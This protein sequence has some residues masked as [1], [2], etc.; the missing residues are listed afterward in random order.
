M[1]NEQEPNQGHAEC[2]LQDTSLKT[3]K[4][5]YHHGDLRTVL[6]DNAISILRTDG[7]QGLSMRKLATSADVSRTAPY[8]HFKDKKELLCAI[9]EEGFR[10]FSTRVDAKTIEPAPATLL[11]FTKQY[12]EFALKNKE[13]YELMFGSELWQQHS[14]TESLKTRA[15]AS[16]RQYATAIKDWHEDKL[17]NQAVDPLRFAQV[18]WSTLHGMSRLL[19]DGVYVDGEAIDAMCEETAQ[20]FWSQLNPAVSF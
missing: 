11:I 15:H 12:L 10:L 1:N 9:A 17:I 14:T 18:S 19:I 3:S 6:L 4:K 13:V 8:H 20:L 7:I 2:L 5:S 16:F